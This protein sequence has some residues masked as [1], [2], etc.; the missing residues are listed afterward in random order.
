MKPEMDP[1]EIYA[2]VE[3]RKKRAEELRINETVWTLYKDHLKSYPRWKT[4]HPEYIHPRVS[5]PI[6]LPNEGVQVMVRGMKC[7]F[8]YSE[9]PG[10][11]HIPGEDNKVCT[12]RLSVNEQL[13]LEFATSGR[14]PDRMD[15]EWEYTM[16]EIDA[17]VEG[18]WVEELQRLLPG[19]KGHEGAAAKEEGKRRREDPNTLEELKRKFGI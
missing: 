3:R 19:V 8:S 5:D 15:S 4:K 2:E 9:G 10:F 1:E 18:P 6:A 11:M 16:L 17:F 14:R 13:V 7:S 12:L